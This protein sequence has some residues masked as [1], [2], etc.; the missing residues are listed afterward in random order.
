M[1][2]MCFIHTLLNIFPLCFV[3]GD[4]ILGHFQYKFPLTFEIASIFQINVYFGIYI[5]FWKLFI[6]NYNWYEFN[7]I[8]LCFGNRLYSSYVSDNVIIV[9]T[10]VILNLQ[11]FDQLMYYRCS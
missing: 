4:D 1:R 6:F 5:N 8:E 10:P 3:L 7:L 11:R 2:W 9:K